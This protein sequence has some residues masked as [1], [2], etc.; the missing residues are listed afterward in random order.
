M[1]KRHGLTGKVNNPV[2]KPSKHGPTEM[3]S[4]RLPVELME[5]V[6]SRTTNVTEF[7]RQALEAK[8]QKPD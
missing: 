4:K 1:N 8:L 6:R 2:G 7:I 5:R 3:V